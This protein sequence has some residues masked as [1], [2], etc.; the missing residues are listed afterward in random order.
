MMTSHG[1]DSRHQIKDGIMRAIQVRVAARW[2][3]CQKREEMSA[4]LAG[5]RLGRLCAFSWCGESPD[6]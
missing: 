3:C 2:K 1:T 4:S 5:F 6:S